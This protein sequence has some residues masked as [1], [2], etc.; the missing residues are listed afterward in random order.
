MATNSIL[1]LIIILVISLIC[2]LCSSSLSMT[3]FGGGYY[4]L[5]NQEEEE[6]EEKQNG[7]TT[8]GYCPS[9]TT[10]T[11]T[12]TYLYGFNLPTP[13]SYSS[14]FTQ[15]EAASMC[16]KYGG[17]QPNNSSLN[18]IYTGL[19]AANSS[20]YPSFCTYV[21]TADGAALL[22]DGSIP[23]GCRALGANTMS[24]L[25]TMTGGK[26]GALCVGSQFPSCPNIE[27]LYNYTTKQTV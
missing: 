1:V 4:Y 16:S 19:K 14:G 11:D 12:D 17:T 9:S 5:M 13:H 8:N 18:N 21:W 15:A 22:S 23:K 10:T 27:K 24:T 2:S 3:G 20:A 26:G 25:P 7:G 6:E